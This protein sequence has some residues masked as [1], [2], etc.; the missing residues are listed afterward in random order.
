[1]I[2]DIKI[3]IKNNIT[4]EPV[5]FAFVFSNF[6][7]NGA[8]QN[9]NILLQKICMNSVKYNSTVCQNQ[10]NHVEAQYEIIKETNM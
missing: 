1:M 5:I 3:W 9:T 4:I 2:S 6:V 7:A 8:Q 10:H